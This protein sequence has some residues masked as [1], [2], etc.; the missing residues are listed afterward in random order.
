MRILYLTQYFPPEVGATQTRAYEMAHN[1]VRLGH[2]VTVITEIPNHPSGVIPPEY[3]G[4]LYE[5]TTLEGI[6]VI[7]VWVK[8]SPI[9]NF[10]NR[11]WFYLSYMINATLAGLILARQHYDLL[12]VTSPPLFVGASGLILARLRRIPLVFEVRDLWPESAIALGE[13]THPTAIAWAKKL[14]EACYRRARK[15]IVVTQ[16]IRDHLLARGIADE[17]IAL[18]PNGANTQLFRFD[19]KGRQHLRILLRLKDKFVAIYAG[20]HGLAQGLETIVEAANQLRREEDFHFLLIGEGPKKDELIRLADQLGLT[21]ITFLPE[22][23]RAE[24]P[25][26]LSAADVA[27]VPLRNLEIFKG[28]LP[29]KVFDAWACQRAVLLSIEGEAREIVEKARGGVF[30]PPEQPQAMVRALKELYANPRLREQMGENGRA[31][32]EKY[33]SRQ[34]LAET[35][36]SLLESLLE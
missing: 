20:I 16:G 18:I 21:N 6:E 24:M 1:L 32:T 19:P 2:H 31:Y 25:G 5:Y 29:S 9:K 30:V 26:Y 8:T 14:E 10:R 28:A 3:R 13:L 33:Y 35:L 4:K 34:A 11:M 17:K 22:K 12:Y 27:L 36:A 23:T 7:R 15:I